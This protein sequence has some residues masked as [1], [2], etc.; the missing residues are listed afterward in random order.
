MTREMG[1]LS[2]SVMGEKPGEEFRL[3]D[4]SASARVGAGL[5]SWAAWP[6]GCAPS[7]AARL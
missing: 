4:H 1:T 2:S 3:S 6:P 5:G 7:P